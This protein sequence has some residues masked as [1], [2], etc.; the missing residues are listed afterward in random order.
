MVRIVYY[1]RADGP[2]G[3]RP[4]ITGLNGEGVSTMGEWVHRLAVRRS[5]KGRGTRTESD[6]LARNRPLPRSGQ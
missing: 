3:P 2:T 1:A 4:T 6:P 5:G